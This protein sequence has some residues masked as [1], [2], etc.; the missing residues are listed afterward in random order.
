VVRCQR[1]QLRGCEISA[2]PLESS[3]YLDEHEASPEY[4]LGVV[5]I[6]C[7]L[8]VVTLLSVLAEAGARGTA[9]PGIT[10]DSLRNGDWQSTTSFGL[11]IVRNACPAALVLILVPL[12]AS[13]FMRA[14][15]AI[16]GLSE[17]HAYLHRSVFGR[18][19]FKPYLLVKEGRIAT[20]E[21]S[22]LARLG[23]PGNVVIY[24]DSA[25]VL[26]QSGRLTQVYSSGFHPLKRFE[27][28][29]GIV[30]LRPQRWVYKVMAMT[31]EGI[32]VSCEADVTFKIDGGGQQPTEKMP[33][34]YTEEAILRA[35]TSTWIREPEE[36]AWKMDWAG[37]VI[38]SYTEGTLR[39]IISGYRLDWLIAPPR[40]G[41][42]PPRQ[43]IR[44]ELE[45]K[46]RE[47][48]GNVGAEIIKVELGEIEVDLGTELIARMVQER[49]EKDY[50]H[51][52]PEEIIQ[53]RHKELEASGLKGKKVSQQWIKAWQAEWQRE[54]ALQQAEGEA[55]LARLEAAQV[56]A[57][58]EMILTF[59]QALQP[60]ISAQEQVSPYLVAL[61]L[62]ET[63]R[64]MS[65]DPW[66]R[67]FLPP[68]AMRTLEL[69]QSQ[70]AEKPEGT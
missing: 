52:S 49:L 37:R 16:D 44:D 36:E 48:V 28:V 35:A 64:W 19:G 67:V 62:I 1:M 22:L 10:V 13:R 14:L 24:N 69:L 5:L 15:Y 6:G 17:A 60:L 65:Y 40:P 54:A 57:Q 26:E 2:E 39:S 27:R 21:D 33:Y 56:Q 43:A 3:G 31:K 53:M 9:L 55:E 11:A 34:P 25:V 58:A 42:T 18:L 4:L 41:I 8:L 32:P 68:E 45:K 12:L 59:A 7:V 20:G 50:P 51:L 46:L 47:S 23:G 38:I 70:I 66:K 30:D 63:L 61:R 29:W